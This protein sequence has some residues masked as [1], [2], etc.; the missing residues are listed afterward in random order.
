MRK[1]NTDLG[2]GKDGDMEREQ[3]GGDKGTSSHLA[4]PT[5]SMSTEMCRTSV[6][7]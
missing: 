7:V 5:L 3:E 1:K 2:E 6:N 4:C